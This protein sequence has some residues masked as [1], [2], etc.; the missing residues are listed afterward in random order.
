MKHAA[1]GNAAC[2][3]PGAFVLSYQKECKIIY[4]CQLQKQI[5]FG[6][7]QGEE[8]INCESRTIFIVTFLTVNVPNRRE[9]EQLGESLEYQN[10]G[11]FTA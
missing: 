3:S 6:D 9:G 5:E 10:A 4:D 11:L 1:K 8:N 2:S 7:T